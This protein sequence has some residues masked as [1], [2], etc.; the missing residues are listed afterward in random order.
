MAE[1]QAATTAN[2][3]DPTGEAGEQP[4]AVLVLAAGLGLAGDPREQAGCDG[5]ADVLLVHGRDEGF[6]ST[7]RSSTSSAMPFKRR[8]PSSRQ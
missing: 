1:V 3:D 2:L 5:V 6:V 8:G 7:W 4:A